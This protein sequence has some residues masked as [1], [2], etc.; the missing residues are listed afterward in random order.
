MRR[1]RVLTAATAAALAVSLALT[2]SGPTL[3]D[4]AADPVRPKGPVTQEMPD[5]PGSSERRGASTVRGAQ[6]DLNG[7]SPASRW[8]AAGVTTFSSAELARGMRKP[9][10]SPVSVGSVAGAPGL[11]VRTLSQEESR[12]LGITGLAFGLTAVPASGARP[13]RSSASAA[14]PRVQVDY[15]G[16]AQAYGGDWSSRLR[17][18]RLACM[19][20]ACETAEVVPGAVNDLRRSTISGQV[21]LPVA[22]AGAETRFAVTAEPAGPNGSYRATSLAPSSSWQVSPQTGDFTWSYPLRV[23]PT[24]AGHE[25][26][27]AVS[28]SSASVDGQ[29]ASTNNQTSWLGQ[30]HQLEPGF[31]ERKF[32]ACVDDMSGGNNSEKTGDLCW[33]SDDNGKLLD[34]LVL[35]LGGRSTEIIKVQTAAGEAEQWRLQADDGS[36]LTR[37]P[38]S[39]NGVLDGEHWVLT[40]NDGSKYYFGLNPVAYAPARTKSVLTVPVFGNHDGE[41]CHGTTYGA[42]FCQQQYRWNVDQV[43][44]PSGT[45]MTYRYA[46]ENNYYGRNNND[47]VSQYQRASYISAIEYGE[48]RGE[49]TE[50]VPPAWVSFT[51]Y[52]RCVQSEAICTGPLNASTAQYWPDVPFDQICTSATSCPEAKSPT[53]FSR[54]RLI[55]VTTNIWQGEIRPVDTWTFSH[56]YPET[57]DGTS[58]SLWLRSITHK[59]NVNGTATDPSMIFT[60]VEMDNRVDNIRDGAAEMKKYRVNSIKTESGSLVSVNYLPKQCSDTPTSKPVHP[61]NNGMRCMPVIWAKP[62]TNI[63]SLDYF[64]KYPVSY[65]DETDETTDA[66]VKKTTYEYLGTTAWHFDNNILAELKDRTWGDWRGYQTVNVKV[67]QP[68]SQ[69]Q[70]KYLY[71]RG[72]HGDRTMDGGAKTVVVTDSTGAD[73]SD[74][75]RLNGYVREEIKYNGAGGAEV[76]GTIN[77]P[78]VSAS[79]GTDGL[80]TATKLGTRQ[81]RSRTRLGE[82]IY[83]VVGTNT[84]FDAHGMPVEVDDH[85]DV[86]TFADDRCKRISYTRNENAWITSKVSRE[87]TIAIRCAATPNRAEDLVSDVRT[88]YDSHTDLNSPPTR[89]LVTKIE[90]ANSWSGGP[91]MKQRSKTTYD[92]LGRVRET[93]D[94][95]NHLINGVE[96]TPATGALVTSTKTIN[97]MGHATTQTFDPAWGLPI[98]SVDP[99]GRRTDLTYDPSGRVTAIW[100]PDRS[101][102][103]GQSASMQF[104]YKLSQTAPSVVTARTLLPSGSY[105]TSKTLYDGLLRQRQVQTPSA[106]GTGRILADIRY[107]NR[108]EE[109]AE[110]LP[111]YDLSVTG[112]NDAVYYVNEVDIPAETVFTYDG[113]GR[114]TVQAFQLRNAEKW[115]TST[116]YGGSYVAVTPPN[117]GTPTATIMDARERT[118]ELR[119]YNGAVLSDTYNSTKYT[120]SKG[121]ELESITDARGSVWRYEYDLLGRKV[122]T[123]DPDTGVSTSTYDDADRVVSA[124]DG[125]GVVL[126]SSYD[127]INRLIE[128]REGSATGP[129]RAS[130]LHDSLAKGQLTSS[131]RHANGA[132]Y[133]TAVTGYDQLYRAKGTTLTV[134]SAEGRLAG[135]YTEA[136]TYLPDG[137]IDTHQLAAVPGVPTETLE[138]RY[139]AA[140]YLNQMG[141]YGAYV[142][143]TTYMA[144]GKPVQYAVG[145]TF[146][147]TAWQTFTYEVGTE[148]LATWKVTR[149]NIGGE[150]LFAYAYDNAGNV[151]S[152]TQTGYGAVDRQC[153]STDFL[154]RVVEA[155]TPTDATCTSPDVAELGGPSPY[156]HSYR[157]SAA[158]DRT[159]QIE[160]RPTGGNITRTYSY[161]VASDPRP[162]GVTKVS[163]T[164]GTS[165]S[166]NTY[167]YDAM[168]NLAARSENGKSD[169]FAWDKEGN[170]D[171]VAGSVGESTFLYTAEG[172]RLI[173]RDPEGSTL[174]LGSTEVRWDKASN[175]VS[176]TRFYEFGGKTIAQ[177]TG[178]DNADLLFGDHHGTAQISVG[179]Y[180]A[181][182]SRR[183]VDLFGN[184]RQVGGPWSLSSRGF[185][186][187]VIDEAT[188]LTHLGAREYDPKLGRFI[189]ADPLMDPGDPQTLNGYAYSNNNPVTFT[190]P[191]GL[192]WNEN[193]EFESNSHG[194]SLDPGSNSGSNTDTGEDPLPPPVRE[195]V[196]T[197]LGLGKGAS[198]TEIARRSAQLGIRHEIIYINEGIRANFRRPPEWMIKAGQ[199]LAEAT[200]VADTMNCMNNWGFSTCGKGVLYNFPGVKPVKFGFKYG[201]DV[202]KWADDVIGSG[203]KGPGCSFAGE[204]DVLMADGTRKPISQIQ[205]GDQVFASD[206]ETGESGARTVT[207]TFVHADAMSKLQLA[208]GSLI[209]TEDHPFWNDSD[210]EFQRA[211]QLE[212]GDALL[213]S[214]GR[215]VEVV[216]PVAQP[217]K[218]ASAYN[219]TVADIHTYY[220]VAGETPILVHNSGGTGRDRDPLYLFGRNSNGPTY[221]GRIDY[222]KAKGGGVGWEMH[223]YRN[224]KEWGFYNSNGW[225]TKHSI[226]VPNDVP[227]G[228]NNRLKGYAVDIGRRT[229][230]I[231]PGDSIKGDDFKRAVPC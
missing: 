208:G 35:S 161:P 44:D 160:H 189:S 17:L 144:N 217:Q 7:R 183:R 133:R 230:D 82:G 89:G 222:F 96:Y 171:K 92:D 201:D 58:K 60:G 118:V 8:P 111:Y 141:G 38:T 73:H 63:K 221:T 72:M 81:T 145:P 51:T 185:V 5:T 107:N 202:L 219:L 64:H 119:Q 23:P 9:G 41:P 37:V 93:F 71:F 136:T 187:G 22:P 122:S 28:Y 131:T 18:V 124:K 115:R 78:W 69:T 85:G 84:E 191:S 147:K 162:H 31:I 106:T 213:T 52:E 205:V 4:A 25:P 229:G 193:D 102:V 32:V 76:T 47:A 188:R 148:R 12:R 168:G 151:K 88:Y 174:Y 2:V 109:Y 135:T 116:Y 66:P 79:T 43:V 223:V 140:G 166:Q 150:E 33:K 104:A 199:V 20:A 30:G 53:F 204:T 184:I 39:D 42:S 226:P 59:G 170:L 164:I 55:A 195:L 173:R 175:T 227:D 178:I 36:R 157:Y 181:A 91:V 120:Y 143:G 139:N 192:M 67:G 190:D 214:D 15:S 186:D 6:T 125:R 68:G 10:T 80:R 61:S 127:E 56:T 155:W 130:W 45:I 129:L 224:Q 206:P 27:L 197:Q 209:T 48:R 34:V 95:L 216:A 29:V 21:E 198:D 108:G 110:S 128:I 165:T 225:F 75:E 26:E 182:Y 228:L 19:A 179:A 74:L 94:G 57:G 212:S 210:K 54:R 70:T 167:D 180:T 3:P 200:P 62:L 194:G 113:A 152:L 50:G 142:A 112:P 154:R 132:A 176:S 97:G 114:P 158:G 156:W 13:D 77:T 65:V 231:K 83:R 46:L 138:Y 196:T 153:F 11:T 203:R 149:E 220:V 105:K 90:A 40:T 159:T 24:S 163:T 146:G 137:S 86:S 99:N 207:A 177:R 123:T 14:K 172:D 49:E 16:F 121:S 100:L 101:K 87:E 117:G 1:S 218:V 134:P 103:G 126:A 98:S 215:T 211:D 169:T